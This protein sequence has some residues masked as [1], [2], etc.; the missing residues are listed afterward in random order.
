MTI[1]LPFSTSF[2][3]P[4]CCWYML[5][6]HVKILSILPA[7]RH[8]IAGNG[9]PNDAK[10]IQWSAAWNVAAVEKDY[11]P[12]VVVRLF[13]YCENGGWKTS[14]RDVKQGSA[15]QIEPQ[16]VPL[17]NVQK[18]MYCFWCNTMLFVTSRPPYCSLF[19]Y[20]QRAKTKRCPAVCKG[21][22]RPTVFWS[23]KVFLP[24]EQKEQLQLFPSVSLIMW[25]QCRKCVFLL[26]R[27]L[28]FLHGSSFQRWNTSLKV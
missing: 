4:Q 16:S 1:V 22:V 12:E 18:V 27:Q 5:L 11:E 6:N 28:S 20:A 10:R 19:Q 3:S 24:L 23:L 15:D 9:P 8:S 26:Q 21:P 17:L 25:H 2:I 13:L 14:D 7:P